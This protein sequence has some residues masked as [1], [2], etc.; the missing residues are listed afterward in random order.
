MSL[1]KKMG[2]GRARL[3]PCCLRREE[4]KAFSPLRC[5]PPVQPPAESMFSKRNFRAVTSV[6]LQDFRSSRILTSPTTEPGRR[7]WEWRLGSLLSAP[8]FLSPRLLFA[9]LRSF[10]NRRQSQI[11]SVRISGLRFRF[12]TRPLRISLR[13][14]C[15]LMSVF[16]AKIQPRS[17]P[18]ISFTIQSGALP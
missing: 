4:W 10:P 8:I 13:E 5:S 12:S 6:I 1:G 2:L 18:S 9:D 15:D 16:F 14:L 3:Q 7:G 17:R 11:Q